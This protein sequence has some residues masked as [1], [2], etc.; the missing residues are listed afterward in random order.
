MLGLGALHPPDAAPGDQP[1]EARADASF[2][3]ELPPATGMRFGID[4][5]SVA[6]FES[7]VGKPDYATLWIGKWTLDHGWRGTDQKLAELRDREVT[8]A[9]HLYYWGDDLAPACF[10][11]GCNGKDVQ[12]WQRLTE[13]L[14]QHLQAVL[15]GRPALVI[16]ESEFNKHGV[17]LDERLDAMLAEKATSLKAGYPSAQ[18]VLGLGNWYP[19]A[20]A[21]WDQAAAASD[22]IGIQALAGSTRDSQDE[23]LALAEST[24][25]GVRTARGLFEKPVVVQDVAVSSYPEPDHLGTQAEAVARLAATLPALQEEGVEL[26]IYRS[27]R[28]SPEMGLYNHYAEAERHWGLAWH[29]TGKLKPAGEAWLAAIAKARSV[30]LV[31]VP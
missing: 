16:L 4:A 21:T 24:L 13:E 17:H 11:E 6:H 14:A 25:A 23:V 30:P 26:V 29:D 10:H 20:W 18:V 3:P 5:N 12:S 22:Y 27:L 2:G 1:D 15:E 7:M 28:D 31:T 9:L 8:P 19:Q